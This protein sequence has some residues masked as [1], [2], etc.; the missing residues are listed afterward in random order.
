MRPDDPLGRDT[1]AAWPNAQ[2]DGLDSR[3]A[4]EGGRYEFQAAFADVLFVLEV[5]GEFDKIGRVRM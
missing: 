1:R 4:C 3:V 5:L 2:L